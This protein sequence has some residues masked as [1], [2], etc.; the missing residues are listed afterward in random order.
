MRIP[1]IAGNWKMHKTVD[2]SIELTNAIKRSIYEIEDVETVLC[3]PFTSLS[4]VNEMIMDT[5]IK[6]GAQNC[7]WLNEGAYTGEIAPKML[8]SVGCAYVIIGHS[9]R[10]AMFGETNETV[11]KKIVAALKEGLKP[12]MCVGEKLK[13]REANKTFDVIKDHVE[14]GLK[15]IAGED[16]KNIVIAYE[17]VWAIGTGKIATP[18]QAEEVHK[19]IRELILKMYDKSVAEAL[20]IQYGGS[21]KPDNVEGIMKEADVDGALVGGA[22]LKADSFADLIKKTNALGKG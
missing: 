17:P 14:G 8:K 13:E 3:P 18:K 11:N 4:D 15:G 7:Y 5:N 16:M 20:R 1:I 22:S 21:V 10:R 6:L 12:I 19:F 2:E 9:E